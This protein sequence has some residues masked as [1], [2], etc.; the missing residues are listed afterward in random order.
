MVTTREVVIQS[1][2]CI[3]IPEGVAGA[4]GMTP[5]AVL[6]VVVDEVAR[7]L[8]LTSQGGVPAGTIPDYTACPVK[9]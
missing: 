8:T 7:S 4:L 5:G 2:G 6:S 3:A 1:C 9:A